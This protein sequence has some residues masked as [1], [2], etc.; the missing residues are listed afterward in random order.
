[1]RGVYCFKSGTRRL[2]MLL[3]IIMTLKKI[4]ILEYALGEGRESYKKSTLYALINVDNCERPLMRF[5]K[6]TIF[7]R[8]RNEEETTFQHKVLLY[9]D[10]ASHF[11]NL[12]I[13]SQYL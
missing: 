1:M 8:F 4:N 10:V 11:V 7:F 6:N 13:S 12:H 2:C 3:L 5:V 9:F